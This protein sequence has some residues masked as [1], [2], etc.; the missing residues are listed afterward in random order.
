MRKDLKDIRSQLKDIAE[1]EA[2]KLYRLAMNLQKRN[3]SPAAIIQIREEA[4]ELE[5]MRSY[6]ERLLDSEKKWEYAFKC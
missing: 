2:I 3:G 5:N 1:A 4:N 6:P